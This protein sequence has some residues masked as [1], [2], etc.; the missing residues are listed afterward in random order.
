M[1]PGSKLRPGATF[2]PVSRFKSEPRPHG[3]IV[4][5]PVHVKPDEAPAGSQE[6][7]GTVGNDLSDRYAK[8]WVVEIAQ[9]SKSKTE[10]RIEES[11]SMGRYLRYVASALLLFSPIRA[12][13]S[14]AN[15]S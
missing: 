7:Y 5:V 2:T 3:A 15:H 8:K 4:K 6:W 1:R 14:I 12:F 9:P 11:A 10:S 13:Q